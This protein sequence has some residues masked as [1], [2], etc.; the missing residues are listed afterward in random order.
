MTDERT[1][2]QGAKCWHFGD[3]ASIGE[4]GED[5][6]LLLPVDEILYSRHVVSH[7]YITRGL[8]LLIAIDP[9]Q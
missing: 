9:L 3:K 2:C 4:K 8:V 1:S 7:Q 5:S 6:P